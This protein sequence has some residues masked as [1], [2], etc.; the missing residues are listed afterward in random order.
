MYTTDDIRVIEWL[1]NNMPNLSK[2]DLWTHP[3]NTEGKYVG[4]IKNG[5]AHGLGYEVF[6]NKDIQIGYW[7]HG[8]L[9]D[10][11]NILSTQH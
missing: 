2:S 1:V 9:V 11:I 6:G 8:K 7:E 4:Q 5:Q 10:P 3:D